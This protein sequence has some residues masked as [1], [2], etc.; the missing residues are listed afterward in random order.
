MAYRTLVTGGCGFIGRHLVEALRERGDEVR[1]LDLRPWQGKPIDENV[2]VTLGCIT[3]RAAVRRA[4]EGID[5]V[6]H[7][8]ANPNLWAPDP[9]QFHE[10]NFVGTCRVLEEAA[11]RR[12][13]RVIYTSTESILKSVRGARNSPRA[14]IDETAQLTLDDMPGPYCRSKFRA[15]EA[16]K[17]AA[18]SGLPVVIV[19]PTMPLGPGDALLTPPTKMVLGFVNGKTPAYL[20]CEFN[21]VDARDAAR[22]HVLAAERGRIGERYILG[23]ENVELQH[24]LKELSRLTG[25]TM[26]T[27]RVPYCLAFAAAVV[28]ETIANF[29]KEPP[30]APITGVRLA[31]SSMAFNC[32][33]A[34]TELGWQPRP[35]RHTL[36]DA[37]VWLRDTGLLSREI[38]LPRRSELVVEGRAALYKPGTYAAR[39]LVVD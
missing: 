23:G 14:I 20:N 22:G 18:A 26:P 12:V 39:S 21:L 11:R 1:I 2:Q 28:S 25:H 24:L 16:A 6:F 19:N 7:V 31:R 38:N 17:E 10:V 3:D 36:Y 5:R 8:A 13:R 30:V 32:S 9:R 35:L 4:M 34:R 29:R 15:E 33:K 37:L 27:V